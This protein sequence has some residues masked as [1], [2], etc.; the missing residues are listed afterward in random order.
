MIEFLIK[1]PIAVTMSVIAV[2]VL[3]LV[4]MRMLPVSL[5]PDVDVP[6]V[7]VQVSS[8]EMSAREISESVISPL[9]RELQQ[10]AHLKDIR[11]EARDGAGTIQMQ[12][13]YEADI[14]YV[15]IEVNEKIDR[16]MG[17]LP[18]GMERPRVLKASAT[19]LPAFF[20]TMRLKSDSAFSAIDP[21]F[22]VSQRFMELSEFSEQ[23]IAK[24][25]EQLP[26]VAMVDV[27]GRVF[28]E[29]LIIPDKAKLEAMGI[30]L[31]ELDRAIQGDVIGQ[32]NL[33]I[34][35]GEYQYS[36]RFSSTLSNKHDIEEVYFKVQDRLFQ[37]RDLARVVE[38][39]QEQEGIVRSDGKHAVILAVIKQ[40][41]AR[42]GD[43]KIEMD[44]LSQA[45]AKDYPEIEFTLT[46]DQTLLLE[47]SIDN[48]GSNL[49]T[50][51]VLAILVIFLFMGDFRSPSLIILTIPLSLIISLLVFFII[52]LSINIISLAGLMLGLGMM[53]DNTII[54]ID[55]V[56][57]KWEKKQDL[58]SSVTQG[59]SEVF[60]PM[61]S[62]TLTSCA[63]FLP[64]IFLSGI[65]GALFYD[66]AM[67]L[68]IGQFSSLL[69]AFTAIPVYYYTLY[70]KQ[71]KR[72]LHPWLKPTQ[73]F[74]YDHLYE[75]GVK[76]VFRHPLPVLL[77]FGAMSVG[78]V[79]LY[80]ILD[81]EKLPPLTR[82]DMMVYVEWNQRISPQENDRRTER[83]CNALS[84][85]PVVQRTSL[86]GTQ[87][88]MLSHTRECGPSEALIYIK[89]E[90]PEQ[91]TAVEAQIDA[92]LRA[93]Y[94]DALYSIEAADNIF[95]LIFGNKEPDL[96]AR[97]R[98]VERK[99]PRPDQLTEL[100]SEIR[101]DIPNLSI[102][103]V[104]WQEHILYVTRPDRMA[105]YNVN[106]NQLTN[107]ITSALKQN[108]MFTMVDGRY[109][110][111]VVM[112]DSESSLEDL[113]Q[114]VTVT[115]ADGKE[116]P[117]SLLL[118]ETRDKDLKTFV[119]GAEGDY[120]PLAL[121]LPS[122][123]VKPVMKKI[124]Q[125]VRENPNFEVS[126]SGAF[127]SNRIMIRELA[128]T[129]TIA[130]FL[131]YFI[132]AAQFESLI[133]PL[134]IL[135]EVVVDIFGAFLFLWFS[136]ASINLMSM[137]GIV[138]MCGIIINDS[139]LKVDTINRLRSEGRG[140]LRAILQGGGMRIKPIIMTALTTILAILPFLWGKGMGAELQFPL[141][142]A[143]IGGMIV[144]T[145]VSLYVIPLFYYYIYRNR[146]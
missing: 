46:R 57:Q 91:L 39:P 105:L 21:L 136:G 80:Q 40:A 95:D 26:Q 140:L 16:R 1:R 4:A 74:R 139:I 29:L 55:N 34:R 33:K 96:V 132:L 3:G 146:K 118:L 138:V 104:A 141:S 42:M 49:L 12:F 82:D 113:L 78:I 121:H 28:P 88:F 79:G 115:S 19:D 112:G 90:K 27:G 59:T 111:P 32:G 86:C 17:S 36:I 52:G 97:I 123:E 48:L 125:T 68:I 7:T 75:K 83:L 103:P 131:L 73:R 102:E 45:F 66:Q 93:S 8:A 92:F 128:L 31:Q 130:L 77:L 22:P 41:D 70:K 44:K 56:T 137:I 20:I 106:N 94:P 76:W 144:G 72:T 10:V 116:I 54:I 51:G 89:T 135:S 71:T 15:F 60:V 145:V 47:Y 133:Q 6:V 23:V 11:S 142:V 81:K 62:S 85:I 120:Y 35:D 127:F 110:V 109:S 124:G 69:V 84:E 14:D 101:T 61:L 143:L 87:D 107:R 63:V 43:L 64:L 9:Q 37:I 58:F 2:V 117:A 25:L 30:S 99:A 38:H 53:V 98:S 119:S 50:G 122:R 129:L 67:A 114:R 134:I 108:R 24:R 13:D 65:A 18:E 100:L 5:M 126:F